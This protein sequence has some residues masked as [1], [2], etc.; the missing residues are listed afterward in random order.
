MSLTLSPMLRK[1]LLSPVPVL[2]LALLL[3]GCGGTATRYVVAAEPAPGASTS[4]QRLR[5][6][7]IELRDV[8]LPA[9]AED[10]A[11][12]IEAADGGLAPVKGSE[13]A[14]NS[15][16]AIT[17]ELARSLDLRSTASVAAEPWPLSD[18]PDVRMEVRI[19]RVIAGASG[20][21]LLSGQY[22]VA[23]SDGR[24]RDFLERFEISVPLADQNP[25]TVA[26][27]Y[28]AALEGLSTQILRRLAR[29]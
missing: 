7:S 13:W 6:G 4:K 14:D 23:S 27:A 26:R 5:V 19:E 16:R 8:V 11:L 2:A 25:Q 9:Y 22:A 29:S 20:S 18:S 15:A 21:F 10:S 3:A 1:S 17:A 28:G 12:L 24:I